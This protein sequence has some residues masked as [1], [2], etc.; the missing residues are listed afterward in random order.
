M[1]QAVATYVSGAVLLSVGLFAQDSAPAHTSQSGQTA[2]QAQD[3]AP[4]GHALGPLEV[5]VNWR[6][7]VEGWYWFEAPP[8]TAS[9]DFGMP[10]SASEL[11]KVAKT[12]TGLSRLSNL[13]FSVYQTMPSLRLPRGN[14]GWEETTTLQTTITPTSPTDLSNRHS[15]TSRIWDR[16]G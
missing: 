4:Q 12:S 9:T 14:S 11:G 1:K 13:L 7:R 15:S 5:S 6:S 16:S 8:A 2:K 3:A 10:S